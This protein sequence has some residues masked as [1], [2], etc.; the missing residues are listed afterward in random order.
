[1][2]KFIFCF[3]LVFTACISCFGF[4]AYAEGDDLFLGGY[5]AGFT[6]T[7][8]GAHVVGLSDVITENGI[9]SPAKNA[10]VQTG[11]IIIKIDKSDVN[12]ANDIEGAVKDACPKTL[13]VKRNGEYLFFSVTPVKDI[14]GNV[15]IGVFVRD[16]MNGI[17][18]ITYIKGNKFGSLGHPVLNEDEKI[19]EISGG[20][21][22]SCE[23]NGFVK[24]ERGTPGELRGTFDKKKADG[25]IQKNTAS[26]VFGTLNENFDKSNLKKITEGSA[27]IGNATIYS[28][29][30]GQEPQE[31]NI[32]IVKTDDHSETKN[33]VIK[34]TDKNLLNLTGGIVQGMSGSPIVQ[35]G[36]LIGAVTHV[37]VNDPSRGFGI[38]IKN[39]LN[40]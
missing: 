23:I 11:D 36:K 38:S 39:M 1:M 15:K 32:S 29:I 10:G 2:K 31:Y 27:K 22:F 34:V 3:L 33:F 7:S 24:G 5:A 9:V 13:C 26:G 6:L 8:K 30:T 4:T 37:F 40:N 20:K 28:T 18:T 35:D 16:D 17:G 21:I 19:M 14:C 25:V 12:D